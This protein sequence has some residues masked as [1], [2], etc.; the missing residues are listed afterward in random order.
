MRLK[1]AQWR[2]LS[3]FVITSYSIHY[4]KLYDAIAHARQ[5]KGPIFV[6]LKVLRSQEHNV[7]GLNNEGVKPRSQELMEEWKATRDPLK[8]AQATILEE[9]I[10]TQA[11]IDQISADAEQEAEDMELYCEQSPKATP[12]VEELMAGVYARSSGGKSY[13]F[14]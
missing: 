14:V 11:E 2:F 12:S 6:E 13:N 10:F 3:D 4:T 7:G 8:L 1:G 9:G 5:G